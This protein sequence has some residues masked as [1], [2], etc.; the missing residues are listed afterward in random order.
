MDSSYAS[1]VILPV[2]GREEE[3]SSEAVTV[4]AVTTCTMNP[5]HKTKH[6]KSLNCP[7]NGNIFTLA[8][9]D[10]GQS[11]GSAL[12]LGGQILSVYLKSI[13]TNNGNAR[14]AIELGSGI[15]FSA[16]VPASKAYLSMLRMHRLAL[17]SMGWNVVSTDLPGVITSVLDQNISN[18][19]AG[20]SGTV[21][22][23]ELDWTCE[24]IPVDGPFDL[25]I[26]SDT[27][28]NPDL[29]HPF[30]RTV[31]ALCTATSLIYISIERR[32]PALIDRALYEARTTW[33]FKTERI[34]YGKLVKAM[35][36]A[37]LNWDREDW[38]DVEVW[39]LVPVK[40]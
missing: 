13:R 10:D 32:D 14:T 29:I 21:Q 39:K 2:K 5:A 35:Q 23:R 9:S 31:Q 7:F 36:K 15:G 28:Y 1:A 33:H 37:S 18:N 4:R 12:W 17:A 19:S 25:I 24:K 27:L 8:Q 20:L 30:F 6:Y 26:S 34:P 38:D 40:V 16:Y 22:V 11:N 3:T